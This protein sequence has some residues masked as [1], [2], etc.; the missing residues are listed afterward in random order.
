MNQFWHRYQNVNAVLL[1]AYL[2]LNL[3]INL[4]LLIPSKKVVIYCP[5]ECFLFYFSCFDFCVWYSVGKYCSTPVMH[6]VSFDWFLSGLEGILNVEFC[7]SKVL[8]FY[9]KSLWNIS[10]DLRFALRKLK[11]IW[12][13]Y[14]EQI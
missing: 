14:I 13:W 6:T 12:G 10:F 9:Q 5:V 2:F 4:L 3:K 11:F 1:F 7:L 8:I